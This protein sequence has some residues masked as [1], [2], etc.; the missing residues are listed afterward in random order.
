MTIWHGSLLY[1]CTGYFEEQNTCFVQIGE[2]IYLRTIKPIAIGDELLA[3]CGKDTQLIAETVR[4]LSPT[5]HS[6]RMAMDRDGRGNE[7]SALETTAQTLPKKL[8][9][10]TVKENES[11]RRGVEN[12]GVG[13]WVDMLRDPDLIFISRSNLDLKD[14]WRNLSVDLKKKW[15]SSCAPS[16]TASLISSSGARATITPPVLPRSS[17]KRRDAH[18]PQTSQPPAAK[19]RRSL[20]GHVHGGATSGSTAAHTEEERV[21]CTSPGADQESTLSTSPRNSPPPFL[22]SLVR[23]VPAHNECA[24]LKQAPGL[25]FNPDPD[26]SPVHAR[27]T[28]ARPKAKLHSFV[29]FESA[30]TFSRTLGLAGE[31]RWYDWCKT[32]ARPSHVPFSPDRTYKHEGWQGWENFLGT[33]GQPRHVTARVTDPAR[34]VKKN[35]VPSSQASSHTQNQPSSKLGNTSVSFNAALVFAPPSVVEVEAAL[36]VTTPAHTAYM[37]PASCSDSDDDLIEPPIKSSQARRTGNDMAEK[38]KYPQRA[39]KKNYFADLAKTEEGRALRKEEGTAL[40]KEERQMSHKPQRNAGRPSEVPHGHTKKT[41]A[42]RAL[43][44]R[45][46]STRARGERPA[47]GGSFTAHT[48]GASSTQAR[49]ERPKRAHPQT[50]LSDAVVIDE[51]CTNHCDG[52]MAKK[53]KF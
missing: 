26:Y 35:V 2:R 41:I 3:W 13:N 4:L 23:I 47:T 20:T 24:A 36:F 10:W 18:T 30:R 50:K 6:R 17:K 8:Q 12:H 21:P 38:K 49:G 1:F 43:D 46:S 28:L 25:D 32:G 31:R 51:Q 37:H 16:S 34:L 45:A 5:Q 39:P 15:R 53:Q 14:K 48:E 52:P 11:L 19:I 40:R 27:S 22:T 9:R 29:S 44:A 42:H 33:E 7:H